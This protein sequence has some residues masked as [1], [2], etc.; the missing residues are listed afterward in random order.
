M[1]SFPRDKKE[2]QFIK[3]F[4]WE[5]RGPNRAFEHTDMTSTD[6]KES[7]AWKSKIAGKMYTCLQ[8]VLGPEITGVIH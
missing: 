6:F 2:K 7:D 5:L 3:D 8:A 1:T 4:R